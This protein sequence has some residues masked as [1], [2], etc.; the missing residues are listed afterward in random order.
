MDSFATFHDI[1]ESTARSLL[2]C[3]CTVYLSWHHHRHTS[4]T[5]LLS[6]GSW[7]RMSTGGQ[8]PCVKHWT[9]L[10]SLVFTRSRISTSNLGEPP[11]PHYRTTTASCRGRQHAAHLPRQRRRPSGTAHPRRSK[12]TG[13]QPS[14]AALRTHILSNI[15][16]VCR[17]VMRTPLDPTWLSTTHSDTGQEKHQMTFKSDILL[18]TW[19]Q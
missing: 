4:A 7:F 8:P 18:E 15:L 1:S 5:D 19:C 9:E 16:P 14:R 10:T 17:L 6:P 12:P 2:F 11:V 13:A 3:L